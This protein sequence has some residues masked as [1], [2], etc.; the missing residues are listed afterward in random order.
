MRSIDS[1]HI[2]RLHDVEED[3][4]FVYLLMEYCNGGDLAQH[5]GNLK[6]MVF[7]LEKATE[8]LAEVIIGLETLHKEGYLHRDIKP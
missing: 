2:V 6:G 5:Q 1:P 7:P 3:K 4:E 8:V